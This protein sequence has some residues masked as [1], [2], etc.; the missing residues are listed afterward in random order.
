MRTQNRTIALTILVAAFWGCSSTTDSLD[1][2]TQPDASTALDASSANDGGNHNDAG[3]DAGSTDAGTADGGG[4]DG[5]NNGPFVVN[6]QLFTFNPTNLTVPP[7]A[8]VTVNNLDTA[9]HT[10]T[11]QT[12][13][14]QFT[15]GAVNGVQFDTGMI[16]AGQSATFTIPANA[17]HGT[18]VPYFC[19]V[20]KGAMVNQP[21]ITVQ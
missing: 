6:I 21:T 1:G 19:D 7:G 4:A 18:V 17:P 5:G 14:G 16:A 20:H 9:P 13:A 12:V 2:G 8:T 11:S 15:L 10:A 3:H